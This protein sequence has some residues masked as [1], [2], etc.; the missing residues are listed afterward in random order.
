MSAVIVIQKQI[1]ETVS[2]NGKSF[3]CCLVYT[4]R[5][6]VVFVLVSANYSN[7]IQ[8]S[9]N[10]TTHFFATCQYI[11]PVELLLSLYC[12]CYLMDISQHSFLARI[13]FESK[14]TLKKS[15][16]FNHSLFSYEFVGQFAPNT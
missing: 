3:Q 13:D 5:A 11:C 16:V 9:I 12:V 15:I 1:G 2:I 4:R 6:F 7:S 14:F 8:K 10:C